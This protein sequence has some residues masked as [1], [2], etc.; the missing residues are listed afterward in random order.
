MVSNWE[1][2]HATTQKT[3]NTL[4]A[5]TFARDCI[6]G[7]T[8]IEI[9]ILNPGSYH[10]VDIILHDRHMIG[11]CATINFFMKSFFFSE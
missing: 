2:G 9:F 7:K 10:V 11:T 3:S 5:I 6:I 8:F 4:T 1:N